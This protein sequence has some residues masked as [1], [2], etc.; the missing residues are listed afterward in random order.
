MHRRRLFFIFL[1]LIFGIT[2]ASNGQREGVTGVFMGTVTTPSGAPV[3]H[4]QIMVVAADQ[5]LSSKRQKRHRTDR[6][7]TFRLRLPVGEYWVKVVAVGFVPHWYEDAMGRGEAVPVVIDEPGAEV[8]W[9]V[10]ITPLASAHG[11]V[12]DGASGQA[13]DSGIVLIDG[14]TLRLRKRVD[15]VNGSFVAEGLI[16]GAY[17][18]QVLVGGYVTAQAGVTLAVG[19]DLGPI[20]IGLSKGLL[21]SGRVM[22][23]D[24]TA[25]EGAMVFARSV[26]R[27]DRIQAAKTLKDGR[28]QISGLVPGDYILEARKVGFEH[29]FY[30]GQN[31]KENATRFRISKDREHSDVDFVLGQVGAIVG[32]VTDAQNQPIAGARVVAEPV[33]EGKRQRVR[34]NKD[35]FYVLENVA[36]GSYLVRASADGYMPFYYNGVQTNGEATAVAVTDDAHTDAVNFVLLPGGKIVGRIRDR[37]SNKPIGNALVTARWVGHSGVWQTQTDPSGGFVLDDL[38]T[39]DFLLHV[40][41]RAHVSEFYGGTRDIAHAKQVKIQA[42]EVISDIG[43]TLPLREPGDFD[44]NGTINFKDMMQ[45]VHRIMGKDPFDTQLDLDR[46]GEVGLSDLIAF[47]RL[48]ARKAVLEHEGLSWRRVDNETHILTAELAIDHMPAAKGYVLQ[49]N[50]DPEAAELLG[51]KEIDGGPFGTHPLLV[52]RYS[53]TVLVALDGENLTPSDG[54]GALVQLR[55]RLKEEAVAV[56]IEIV[57]AWLSAEDGQLIPLRLPAKFV[58]EKPPQAFRLM[59]NVPNPFNPATTIAFELPEVA[60]VDVAVYNLVGQRLRTLVKEQKAPGRY[61][62]V[63]DGKDDAERDVSSGVYF[64]RYRAGD[65]WATRRMLLVR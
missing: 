33:G 65:F 41:S 12:V 35:G 43:V 4:A 16:P 44:G 5:T 53:G 57:A 18:F 36:K 17:R 38:P 22:G 3:S 30:G 56:P 2:S 45:L 31:K 25:L 10:V 42:G 14:L 8:V 64:Y 54:A 29:A 39:G 51:T 50:F 21:V 26:N 49:I 13:I 59:K 40:Q 34:A 58:L 61:Q 24:G 28:Y 60:D 62:V 15:I 23:Q 9:P 48:P 47:T 27:D 37:A 55:F 32:Q 46:D 11:L 52:Q 6:D 63:W 1:F 19:D 20:E 7:G